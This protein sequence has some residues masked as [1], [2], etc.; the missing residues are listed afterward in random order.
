MIGSYK[1]RAHQNLALAREVRRGVTSLENALC[2]ASL[3]G[4]CE[5]RVRTL[6]LIRRMLPAAEASRLTNFICSKTFRTIL[7]YADTGWRPASPK[8]LKASQ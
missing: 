8:Q 4:G 7:G 6:K 5:E 3:F 1:S 2:D